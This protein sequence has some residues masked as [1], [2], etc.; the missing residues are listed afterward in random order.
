V[1]RKP[2]QAIGAGDGHEGAEL[3][4]EERALLVMRLHQVIRPFMLRRTK[5][6]I[7]QTLRISYHEIYCPITFPQELFLRTLRE[8]KQLPC[9]IEGRCVHRSVLTVE[10]SAQSLCN[11]ALMVPFISQ[12]MERDRLHKISL[13][14]PPPP[15]PHPPKMLSSKKG[16]PATAATNLLSSSCEAGDDFTL[17]TCTDPPQRDPIALNEKVVIP[18]DLSSRPSTGAAYGETE[19]SAA[20]VQETA[21]DMSEC[22]LACPPTPENQQRDGAGSLSTRPPSTSGNAVEPSTEALISLGCSGK[23]LILDL[24]IRR[25]RTAGVKA[26]IFTHWLDCIDLLTE[27]FEGALGWHAHQEY[28][29]LTGASS[30]DERKECVEKFRHDPNCAVFLVSMK[31]GGCGLNLQVT[32]L[33]IML[34]R[35]YTGTNEEQAIARVFRIGQKHV[36]RALYLLTKDPSEQRILDIAAKKDKPR[37][38][39]IEGGGYHVEAVTDDERREMLNKAVGT[40]PADRIDVSSEGL[41]QTCG[42]HLFDSLIVPE[43]AIPSE[44]ATQAPISA[45]TVRHLSSDTTTVLR[46]GY[47]TEQSLPAVIRDAL[48]ECQSD[49]DNKEQLDNLGR[50]KRNRSNFNEDDIVPDWFW[51]KLAEDGIDDDEIENLWSA[52]RNKE[53]QLAGLSSVSFETSGVKMSEMSLSHD[54]APKFRRMPSAGVLTC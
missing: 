39:I 23:L 26:V 15:P 3:N 21:N 33:I 17:A 40:G 46:S 18:E 22:P 11:H 30:S 48:A 32:H 27:Y 49:R 43:C 53:R 54:T 38:A 14:P 19:E 24:I 12:V 37:H 34:D 7:D 20:A 45:A 51:D 4:D 28:V 9:V 10:Q 41:M 35:D 42:P 13:L 2:F 44:D 16:E 47:F 50:G 1:F 52:K 5:R 25:A 29:A 6:D 31:A 36:V 8:E